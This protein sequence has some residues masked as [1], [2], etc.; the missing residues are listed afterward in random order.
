MAIL[1]PMRTASSQIVGDEY[2]G[3]VHH[4]GELQK[5]VLELATDQRVEGAERLVHEQD[6]R[7]GRDC[8]GEADTL[9]HTAGELVGELV[10]P[11][12]QLDHGQDPLRRF[13]APILGD[14]PD[15]ERSRDIVED[16]AMG[17]QG[18]VLKHH[19]DVFVAVAAQRVSGQRQDVLTADPGCPRPSVPASD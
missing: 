15:L 14:A 11:S 4:R 19:R 12:G 18:E 13:P 5:F 3:L 6:L 1:L 8:A 2:R 10:A 9:L 7:I 17:H 16:R